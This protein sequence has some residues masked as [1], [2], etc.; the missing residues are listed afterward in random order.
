MSAAPAV[1]TVHE[2]VLVDDLT[3]TRIVQ[4][5]GASGDFNPLHTDATYA[6]EVAG[7]DGVFGH[8]MLTMGMT[9]RVLTDHYGAGAVRHL[10]GRFLAQVWPGDRLVARAEVVAVADGRVTFDIITTNQDGTPVF[11]GRGVVALD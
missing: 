2:L 1:G 6:T 10:G 11:R 9:G 4:Y 3:R 8:G 7:F 5:A